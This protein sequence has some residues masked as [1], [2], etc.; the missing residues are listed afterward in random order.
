MN[1]PRPSPAAAPPHGRRALLV[2][3]GSTSLARLAEAET[4]ARRTLSRVLERLAH[5]DHPPDMTMRPA[6]AVV[7]VEGETPLGAWARAEA[8][9]SGV[10]W[11]SYSPSGERGR[12]W[13][14]PSRWAEGP[15]H[16]LARNRA[17][18]AA[19][20]RATAS[21][22][23]VEG[24]CLVAAWGLSPHWDTHAAWCLERV[25]VRVRRLV[26]PGLLGA[27]PRGDGADVERPRRDE[28][29][30]SCTSLGT[31]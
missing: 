6:S 12:S 4:W 9:T 27:S 28:G 26:H 24:L 7:L 20:S 19:A 15:R 13:G 3:S 2:V 14:P 16:P 11:V 10:P 1:A 31:S 5:P 25:G 21:G 23:R 8:D 18:A 22:W 30:L 17:M 29:Q